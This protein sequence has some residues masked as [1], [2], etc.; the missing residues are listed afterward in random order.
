MSALLGYKQK[1]AQSPTAA[2]C[3][4]AASEGEGK[5]PIVLQEQLRGR[6]NT[7]RDEC[8]QYKAA[9][10]K[11]RTQDSG[12]AQAADLLLHGAEAKPPAKLVSQIDHEGV[13][14]L[15]FA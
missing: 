7:S 10:C 12:L 4:E 3:K 2:W 11:A 8:K 13:Y 15:R 14:P 1:A 9:F 6:P 5:L